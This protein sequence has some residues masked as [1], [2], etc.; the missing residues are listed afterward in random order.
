MVTNLLLI[1]SSLQIVILNREKNNF[2]SRELVGDGAGLTLPKVSV[3][4]LVSNCDPCLIQINVLDYYCDYIFHFPF[5]FC[6]IDLQNANLLFQ[7][8][9]DSAFLKR[10][11]SIDGDI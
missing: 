3:V 6:V 7:K 9:S 1:A 5:I 4:R 11:E 2:I 8:I 10:H